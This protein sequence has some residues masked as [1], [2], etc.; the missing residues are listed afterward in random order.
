MPTP[1][2]TRLRCNL[3]GVVVVG[4]SACSMGEQRAKAEAAV[5]QFHAHYNSGQFGQIYAATGEGFRAAATEADFTAFLGGVREQLGTISR[6]KRT[7]WRVET[8]MGSGTVVTLS[9]D[10]GFSNGD[11][12]E[13]FVF[14]MRGSDALLHHYSIDSPRLAQ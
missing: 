13:R 6:A 11:G 12:S 1:S 9:Y 14:H 2:R 5:E 4:A 8:T 3:L 7:G 10:V